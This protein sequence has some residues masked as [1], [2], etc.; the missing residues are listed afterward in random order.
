MPE[1]SAAKRICVRPS[2][3]DDEDSEDLIKKFKYNIV[4]LDG[5]EHPTR[6]KEYLASRETDLSFL[7]RTLDRKKWFAVM[8]SEYILQEEEYRSL[9][10]EESMDSFESRN[11]AFAS[12]VYYDKDNALPSFTDP[13]KLRL[14]PTGNVLMRGPSP[15]VTMDDFTSSTIQNWDRGLGSPFQPLVSTLSDV[16]IIFQL[17]LSESFNI[18]FDNFIHQLRAIRKIE[19][20]LVPFEKLRQA[21]EIVLSKFFRVVRTQRYFCGFTDT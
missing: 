16:H 9:L 18:A 13:S 5:V 8:G 11:E 15:T 3:E 21:V 19:S 1:R 4:D 17:L 14:F 12:N 10:I 6:F 20:Y 2:Q 7:F